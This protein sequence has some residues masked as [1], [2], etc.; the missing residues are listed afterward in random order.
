M[1]NITYRESGSPIIPG[2]TT[3]KNAPLTNLEVD[4]NFKA[5]NDDIQTK[6]TQAYV[7]SVAATQSVMMAI[8]L[9]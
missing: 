4:A 6:T 7:D 2:S 8:A 1:A 9:G 3:T 5:L